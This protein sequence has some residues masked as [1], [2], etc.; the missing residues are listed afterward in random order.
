MGLR[1]IK[2][3]LC[4]IVDIGFDSYISRSK[5]REPDFVQDLVCKLFSDTMYGLRAISSLVVFSLLLTTGTF[6]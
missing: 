3:A 6:L 2:N 5:F 1:E 4:S